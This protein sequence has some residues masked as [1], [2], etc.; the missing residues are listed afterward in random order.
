M[1]KKIIS[2]L[3]AAAMLLTSFAVVSATANDEVVAKVDDRDVTLGDLSSK[4]S[5][6]SD[7]L[8]LIKD[9]TISS[10]IEKSSMWDSILDLN[11]HTITFDEGRDSG[12]AAIYI[13]KGKLT[14]KDS[15]SN[16]K[17]KIVVPSKYSK[18]SAIQC[19]TDNE[20]FAN[21][22][23]VIEGGTFDAAYSVFAA[24]RSTVTINGGTFKGSQSNVCTNGSYNK[25]KVTINGVLLKQVF[26][27]R[28]E[29]NQHMK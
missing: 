5:G 22:E 27:F 19:G 8:V 13:S 2:A 28:P 16:K 1:K 21:S 20:E 29:M 25:S 15:S 17:G 3:L 18:P 9:I 10:M 12:N 26:I 24:R 6:N 23:L 14:I 4:L 11:G 7:P